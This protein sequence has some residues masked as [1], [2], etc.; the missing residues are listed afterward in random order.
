[1]PPAQPG[2]APA[3][4]RA[5]PPGSEVLGT[6]AALQGNG[7]GNGIANGNQLRPLPRSIPSRAA[8]A[9]GNAGGGKAA[10]GNATGGFSLNSQVVFLLFFFF[11]P[12]K[13]KTQARTPE[14]LLNTDPCGAWIPQSRGPS[15]TTEPRE[16]S[17]TFPAPA[18]SNSQLPARCHL[19]FQMS[20]P[21][22]SCI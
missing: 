22:A 9:R 7:K 3:S 19:P 15:T 4:S 11:F 18:N 16:Q 5:L 21:A 2:T 14:L 17:E 8:P 10:E 1:M 6:G 20:F 13:L 12:F